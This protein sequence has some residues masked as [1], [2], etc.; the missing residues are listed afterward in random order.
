VHRRLLTALVLTLTLTAST[1]ALSKGTAMRAGSFDASGTG[2]FAAR[3]DLTAFGKIEGSGTIVVRDR[4]GGAVVKLNGVSQRFKLVRVG[5]RVV[6]VYTIPVR[7]GMVATSRSI[8]APT[9]YVRGR[10]VRIELRVPKAV[11]SVALIGRGQVVVL[12]GEGTYSLNDEP[13]ADWIDAPLPI[14]IKPKQ[15]VPVEPARTS[16]EFAPEATRP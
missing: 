6:R 11:L 7:R 16:S 4:A 2:T 12:E 10:D 5:F 14:Q 9:F 8:K 3:G 1:V 15:P 13:P